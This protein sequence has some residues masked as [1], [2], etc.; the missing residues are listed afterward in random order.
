M[1]DKANYLSC[2]G[3]IVG[4]DGGRSSTLNAARLGGRSEMGWDLHAQVGA[5]TGEHCSDPIHWSHHSIAR[6]LQANCI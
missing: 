4:R 5:V 6:S 3:G 2:T 1:L